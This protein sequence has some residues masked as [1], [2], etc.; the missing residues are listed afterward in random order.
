L[1]EAY[2]NVYFGFGSCHSGWMLAFDTQTLLPTGIFNSSPNLDGEGQYASA[3]GVWMG[4]GGPASNGDGF[5]Y[6]TT[7]NGPFDGLTAFADSVLQFNP[8]TLSSSSPVYME[9][10][11]FF[12]PQPVYSQYMD[13]SDGDMASGGLLLIPG[14]TQ[15]L[16]GAKTAWM[17]LVNTANLG[18]Q[19]ANDAGA[20]D[21]LIFENDLGTSNNNATAFSKSCTDTTLIN[22]SYTHTIQASHYEVYGTSA[23]FNGSVYLGITADASEIPGGLRQFTL[24]GNTLTPGTYTAD[25]T[26]EEIRGTTPFISANGTSDG[27]VWMI[28]QGEPLAGSAP[29]ATATLRAFDPNNLANELYDSNMNPGDQPGYG[30]KFTSPIVANGKV[31]ISTGNNLTTA[32]QTQGRIDVYGL[33]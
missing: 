20:L 29:P 25:A 21:T 3:G 18:G 14:T 9:P 17:Y 2:G 11:S 4:G 12:T 1:L 19:Q 15:A 26:Q 22:G 5:V 8:P 32:S 33:N 16:A 6:I 27:V 10:A 13:C 24:S 7:G 28:D 30:I 23:Y 31:Y